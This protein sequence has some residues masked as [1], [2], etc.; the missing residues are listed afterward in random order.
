LQKRLVEITD[1]DRTT[2]EVMANVFSEWCSSQQAEFFDIFGRLSSEWV[3]VRCM[4]FG[5]ITPFLHDEGRDVLREL[6]QYAEK[7]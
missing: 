2:P 3:H 4:Q 7:P 5:A 1:L 6:A